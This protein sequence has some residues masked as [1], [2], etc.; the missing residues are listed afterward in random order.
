MDFWRQNFRI[1]AAP[2]EGLPMPEFFQPFIGS[3]SWKVLIRTLFWFTA[4]ASSWRE[5][6]SA[7]ARSVVQTLADS[8][9]DRIELVNDQNARSVLGNRRQG[10]DRR[11][12]QVPPLTQLDRR[13]ERLHPLEAQRQDRPAL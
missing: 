3:G 1:P 8:Q 4:P 6:R 2:P 13:R 10:S 9:T 5:T 11:D 12:V 7:F